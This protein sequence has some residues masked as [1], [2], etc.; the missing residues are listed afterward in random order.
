MLFSGYTSLHR[1]A[2][3]GRL[4]CLKALVENDA[5]LQIKT[6][7]GERARECAQ[8]YKQQTCVEYLDIAGIYEN[9][10]VYIFED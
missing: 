2:C 6:V 3:W 9:K 4:D 1:A 10:K 7:H 5:D 8:R